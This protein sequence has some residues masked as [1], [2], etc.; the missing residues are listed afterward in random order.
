MQKLTD[1]QCVTIAPLAQQ[2]NTWLKGMIVTILSSPLNTP[3]DKQMLE[4]LLRAHEGAALLRPTMTCV[5]AASRRQL[6]PNRFEHFTHVCNGH[7]DC[8]IQGD[9]RF[10]DDVVPKIKFLE[11]LNLTREKMS[12]YPAPLRD[13][14]RMHVKVLGKMCQDLAQCVS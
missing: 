9:D 10:F 6:T 1:Q 8:M 11:R 12:R 2:F 4:A 3:E 14:V 13:R 7:Y 5:V